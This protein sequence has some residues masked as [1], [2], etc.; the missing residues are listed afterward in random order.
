MIKT[1]WVK[2]LIYF[3]EC[4]YCKKKFESE[5]KDQLKY[6]YGRHLAT[7]KSK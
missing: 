5:F 6:N 4:P 1:K 2:K 3:T 7:C